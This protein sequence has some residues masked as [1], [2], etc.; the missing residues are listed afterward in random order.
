LWLPLPEPWRAAEFAAA[1]RQE[2]VLVKTADSFV[3]GRNAAPHAIRVCMSGAVS[4]DALERGL[5]LIRTTLDHG[6][7]SGMASSYAP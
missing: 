1:L 4:L 6:L 5:A 7:E 3:I 2:G